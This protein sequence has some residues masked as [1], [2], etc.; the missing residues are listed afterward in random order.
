MKLRIATYNVENLFRRAK[1]LN[2]EDSDE[3]DRLLD[4]LRRLQALLN[5]PS[6]TVAI[7]DQVFAMSIELQPYIE[8]RKDSGD[9][10]DW[11]KEPIRTGPTGFRINVTCK[12][13]S[14]WIGEITFKAIEF[15]D[16]QRKNT[17][18][19]IKEV[20]ADI[21]CLTEVEGMDI[22]GQFN[23]QVLKTPQRKY[24][25]FIMVDSPNDPRGIDV[26]CVTKHKILSI[27]THVFDSSPEFRRIFS[28]DC[29]E[30]AIDAG[31]DQPVFVLCN[32]FKSQ[33][34]R[35]LQDRLIGAKKRKAQAARVREI[36]L[37][38][39]DL[40]KQ[41]VVVMGDLNEDSSNENRGLESL[42]DTPNLFPVVDARL[43]I[44]DRYTYFFAK[45][46][47]GKKLNQL[48]YI[49]LSK[50]LHAGVTGFGFERRGIFNIDTISVEQGADLV[51]PFE[52][53]TSFNTGASD[54]AAL[55]V[56]I[57]IG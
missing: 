49:F 38:N 23:S 28:R 30:V 48:D 12:G 53:V 45:G 29:L 4:L 44:T 8:I 1:I 13:R 41:Y 10:G 31:L 46:A 20:G 35:T 9:L 51:L 55:W 34:G 6:Y 40:S 3:G 19:V 33:G 2:L 56:D 47:A 32:H 50:P 18:K 17:G 22:L 27:R 37:G 25:Q 26:A 54:H 42:F 11:K 39:Y 52:T 5:K 36:L 24:S 16:V 7:K 15:S 57:E 43:P 14:D 21:L